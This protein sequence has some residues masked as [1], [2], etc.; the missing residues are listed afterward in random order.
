[1]SDLF[2]GLVCVKVDTPYG[3]YL[4]KEEA[5]RIRE[6]LGLKEKGEG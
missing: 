1:L 2:A 5:E 6:A 4:T 3:V